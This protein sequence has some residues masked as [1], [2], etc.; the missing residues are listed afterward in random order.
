MK[1]NKP[2]AFVSYSNP[3]EAQ[4][5]VKEMHGAEITDRSTESQPPLRFF[6]SFVDKGA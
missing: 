4:E 6:L 3:D 2:Y 5:A 1:P